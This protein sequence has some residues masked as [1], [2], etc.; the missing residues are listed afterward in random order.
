MKEEYLYRPDSEQWC[1]LEIICH[2]LDEEREDFRM[3]LQTVLEAP[4][5]H[6][7]LIDPENWVI[8]RKYMEQDFKKKLTDFKEERK[9]SIK[10]LKSL[11]N[12]NWKNY[13]EHPALGNVDGHHFL[14]NWLAHDY[15][16]IRQITRVKYRYLQQITGSDCSYAGN[17]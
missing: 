7:P 13:Y 3:R 15:L 17:W 9:A 1:L 6:P 8:S 11:E 4:F 16:H 10:Y 5:K 2:L 14:R 12:P